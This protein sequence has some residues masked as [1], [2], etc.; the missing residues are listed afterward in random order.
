MKV[1]MQLFTAIHV[2]IYRLS[3]GRLGGKMGTGQVLLLDS[4]GRKS[5][6]ARTNPVMFI[7]DKS[8][9][10]VT[11][12]A[13]GRPSNPG[14]YYNLVANPSTR[15]Q[16]MGQVLDVAV[17]EA[18][19]EKREQLWAQLTR[20]QPNF[21]AYETRTTRKIPMLILKPKNN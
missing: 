1:F 10:V 20:Q 11:A 6:K 16:V 13:G 21:K 17:E 4:I 15:I 18:R 9:Y 3:G 8:N 12:S 19:G 7:R 14:W 5:K 2:F